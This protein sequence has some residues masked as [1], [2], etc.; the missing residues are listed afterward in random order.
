VSDQDALLAA[1]L[2]NPDEDTARLVF[3]DWLEENG[4][5]ARAEL[6][7]LQC[8]LEPDRDRFDDDA[9]NA[10]HRRVHHLLHYSEPGRRAIEDQEGGWFQTASGRSW[11]DSPLALQWRRGFVETVGAHAGFLVR[12]GRDIR[13]RY[14]LLR[15]LVVFALNGWGGRVAACEW[16]DG[17]RELELACWYSDDDARAVAGSPHLRSV[18]RLICWS[19]GAPGQAE[20]LAR[21]AA[22]PVLRELH[23]VSAFGQHGGWVE[24]VE[25]A[26]GRPIGSVY[27]FDEE[28]YP[29]AHDFY[30]GL[31]GYE[32]IFA[33]KL[34]DG[35][36]L[37]VQEVSQ[38]HLEGR[39]I[40]YANVDPATL[41]MVMD[42]L[43]FDPDGTPRPEPFRVPLPPELWW[44]K[45]YPNHEEQRRAHR[46]RKEFLRRAVGF[47]PALIRVR[48][49]ASDW[50]GGTDRFCDG[51]RDTW[52]VPDAPGSDPAADPHVR[53]GGN[54]AKAYHW[55][56]TGKFDFYYGEEA[57][58]RRGPGVRPLPARRDAELV[59]QAAPA[60]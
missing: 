18:E 24:A 5:P 8:R 48:E 10:L 37:I 32:G 17:I 49:I 53:Q 27:V 35:T 9:I 1:I 54:G 30:K 13:R 7:R 41:A 3:A 43:A 14:P 16:L 19:G 28:L 4:Q 25:A 50:L 23:L 56:R 6:I 52:G 36:Q 11:I 20:T 22:R 42:A 21:G 26:A 34:P 38:A 33:G 55:V 57:V 31:C 58:D 29:F 51:V 46:A 59:L 2:A 60:R 40:D 15:K 12:H 45:T 39:P 47:E 44:R